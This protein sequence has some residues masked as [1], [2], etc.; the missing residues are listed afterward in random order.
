MGLAAAMVTLRNPRYPDQ[1]AIEVEALVDIGSVHMR[2]PRHIATQLHLEQCDQKEV[3]IA[4][5][6]K[7]VV[8]YVGPIEIR[9]KNRVGICGAVVSGDQVLLGAIAMEDVD[10]VVS[11]MD[12]KIDVNPASP[13]IA[14]SIV[15]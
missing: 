4:D 14:G 5:G 13:N 15:K 6:S 1:R 2:V 11:P 8:P 10:L 7:R 12:R 3:K 9:I